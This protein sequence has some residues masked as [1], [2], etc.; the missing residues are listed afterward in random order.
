MARFIAVAHAE[1]VPV[2]IHPGARRY[3]DEAR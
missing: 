1:E 2:E 3:F